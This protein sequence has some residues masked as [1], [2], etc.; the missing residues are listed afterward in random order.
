MKKVW[1]ASLLA[2]GLALTGCSSGAPKC[3]DKEALRLLE[4]FAK[5]G[6]FEDTGVALGTLNL[7]G[8]GVKEATEALEQ[9]ATYME[10]EVKIKFTNFRTEGKNDE[11]KVARCR[12]DVVGDFP[13]TDKR[14]RGRIAA[15]LRSVNVEVDRDLEKLDFTLLKLSNPDAAEVASILIKG[16]NK[17]NKELYY[18]VQL[19]S[20]GKTTNV[21]LLD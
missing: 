3:D 18:Q 4:Q 16:G 7:R 14:T 13:S 5:E 19:S 21:S 12:V 20:D 17:L 11:R 6:W 15:F 10:K 8:G 2:C 1:L 9:Y